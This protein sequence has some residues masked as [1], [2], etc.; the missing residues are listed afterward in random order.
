[1]EKDS[2]IEAKALKE[3]G[4]IFL[5]SLLVKVSLYKEKLPSTGQSVSVLS[6]HG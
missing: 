1:M 6:V 5:L 3:P 2:H 4:I